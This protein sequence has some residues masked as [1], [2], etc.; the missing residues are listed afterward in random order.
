MKTL[1]RMLTYTS[2][3]AIACFICS[4]LAMALATVA[5]LGADAIEIGSFLMALALM[6]WWP[7][8]ADLGPV[9]LSVLLKRKWPDGTPFNKTS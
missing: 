4:H 1:A 2:V 5:I 8:V 3:R 9:C 6:L 7:I